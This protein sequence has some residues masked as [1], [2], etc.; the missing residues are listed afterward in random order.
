[1]DT[2]NGT[3]AERDKTIAERD[4][5]IKGYETDSV[6]RRIAHEVGLPEDAIDYLKGEDAEAL[7]KSAENLKQIIGSKPAA[8]PLADPES[9]G[10][11]GGS[12]NDAAYKKMLKELKGE[13]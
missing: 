3:I 12:N 11:G 13:E 6:K 10:Q 1:M 7:K 9:G 5:K 2:A 8:P 4:A